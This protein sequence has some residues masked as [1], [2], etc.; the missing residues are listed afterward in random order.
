[1]I[2]NSI[3]HVLMG[4]RSKAMVSRKRCFHRNAFDYCILQRLQKRICCQSWVNAEGINKVWWKAINEFR[5]WKFF[6]MP[7]CNIY[8]RWPFFGLRKYIWRQYKNIQCCQLYMI[9]CLRNWSFG[10]KVPPDTT[11]MKHWMYA[12]NFTQKATRCK[13]SPLIDKKYHQ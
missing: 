2:K 5:N 1:M 6:L 8:R 4:V 13:I 11:A 3:L 7:V 10:N 9:S 12:A